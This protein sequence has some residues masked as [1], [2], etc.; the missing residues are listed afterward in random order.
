MVKD[1]LNL[2]F[3]LLANYAK[4]YSD[5]LWNV[6]ARFYSIYVFLFPYIS[7]K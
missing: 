3:T 6:P 1:D 4:E 2:S 5:V 7:S